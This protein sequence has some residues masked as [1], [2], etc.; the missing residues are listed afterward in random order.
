MSEA[1]FVSKTGEVAGFVRERDWSK[2]SL[3]T[4]STWPGSLRTVLR[5]MLASRYAM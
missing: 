5:L 2:T 1:D 3:G 4:P